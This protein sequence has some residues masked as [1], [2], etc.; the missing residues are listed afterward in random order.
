MLET[1]RSAG[2][3]D[4]ARSR[5]KRKRGFELAHSALSDPWNELIARMFAPCCS[6]RA[7]SA[8]MR[9]LDE[10]GWYLLVD[11]PAIYEALRI[12]PRFWSRQSSERI[13]AIMR[14]HGFSEVPHGGGVIVWKRYDDQITHNER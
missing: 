12:A 1:W 5:L 13:A 4:A 7:W 10:R 11:V 3:R 6:A 2:A 9:R 8:G 14:A